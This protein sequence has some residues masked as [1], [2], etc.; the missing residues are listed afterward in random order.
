MK[1][2]PNNCLLPALALV[3]CVVTLRAQESL[4]QTIEFNRDIRPILSDTCYKCHG[5]D[6]AR[7]KADLRLDVEASAKAKIDDHFTIVPGQ[8]G[9]S[10]LIRRITTSDED[11]HMP[12]ADSGVTL[13]SRQ[14]SLLRRWIEQGAKWQAHWSLI[15]PKRPVVPKVQD[16]KARIYNPIDN[17]V[18]A[19][20]ER[21]GI[22]PAP[23]AEPATLIRR[24]SLDLTG[25]PPTPE[26]VTQFLADCQAEKESHPAGT[27]HSAPGTEHSVPGTA[28]SAPATA[29]SALSTSATASP[30][31]YER[32]VDHLLASHSYGERMASRWL[33]AA[34]YADT[35]GYQSD[36][37]RSMWRW[38]DWVIDAF[39]R[40]LPFDRFSV[41]QLAG[42]LLPG[43]TREQHIA[44]GFNRNHRGNAEGGIIPEE[45]AAEYVVDRVDTTATVWLGLTM[46][47]ARCH[48]HKYDPVTQREFYQVF[49]FFNTVPEKGKAIKIGNSPPVISAPTKAQ[50]QALAKLE[51]QLA[52]A[53]ARLRA[54]EPE[55]A[56]AQSAWEKTLAAAPPA[57][58]TVT[59]GLQARYE[60]DGKLANTF[61]KSP[62][63]KFEEGAATFAP[64]RDGMAAA[65]DGTRFINCGDVGDFGFF[66][67]FTLAAWIKPH[68]SEGGAIVSRMVEAAADSAFASDSEGYRVH[69][70]DG[71]VQLHLTKRWLDDALRVET[72]AALPPDR[73]QHVAVVYDGS[74]LASGVKIFVNGQPQKLR[75]LFDQLN[76]TFQTKQPLRIGAGG[77][78]ANRFHGLVSD[79]RVYG[80]MLSAEEIGIVGTTAD[81]TKLAAIP[82]PQRTTSQAAKLRSCFLA[83]HASASQ[84]A[85]QTQV[86]AL[87]EKHAQLVESLPTV[88]VMEEM[89]QPRDTF[90]L[91][92][93]EYDKRGEQVTPNV[94]AS[95]PPLPAD[96]AHNRLGFAQWLVSPANPLTARVAV[97]HQWQMLFG[98]GLV[99]TAEDFGAQGEPPS[100]PE[101]LDWLATEFMRTGWDVKHSLK[102]MVMSAA[103][104]QSSRLTPD[105]LARDPENRLIA[106]GPRVRLPA[107]MIRDQA[108]AVSGLLVDEIGGPSVKPYQPKGL[109]KEL[110]GTD[111]EPDHGDKLWRRSLYTFW[112]RTSPQPTMTTFDAAGRE[113][114]SVRPSRTSTPLQALALMND[115]TFVEA[116]RCLAQRVMHEGGTT[117]EERLRLA[118][119]LVLA[120]APRPP[121][122]AVLTTDLTDHLTRF[123]ASPQSAQSLIS[124]GESAHD[125][126][127]DAVELAAYTAVAGLILNLDEAITKQ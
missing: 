55:I 83:E 41:E 85:A 76:Q 112:K 6:K 47:C 82:S 119:R 92:R 96:A 89:A 115:V 59:Q 60:L 87:R 118:F 120:R 24:V 39:N 23:E 3:A 88:M 72:E 71:R 116:S 106:R 64:G 52:T 90:V 113:M 12:P 86:A 9:Q 51:T 2:R 5:P 31:A 42:D 75:V 19:R 127:L 13:T 63:A 40:N 7:R 94:P 48:D 97:N 95:L 104:R 8:P 121:E 34:R 46:G 70:K 99:K 124:A 111:Y 84:R 69:L 100:H 122:L 15:A 123:R 32:L 103:Y 18:L 73:W 30:T 107:E 33:D 102:T 78:P 91:K 20:L 108:L 67:K 125:A 36:G 45:Y 38:R 79:V 62:A 80:R 54:A 58:W 68:G 17:F 16:S 126:K 66:D 65:L 114:C 57:P 25:L 26:E 29:H 27:E 98:T 21:E 1:F 101:L 43:A 81:T 53:E 77:G 22:Q 117:P 49:A 4:P 37:E 105:L 74:R 14:A 109:Q 61:G 110:S 50:D 10:E 44:T 11:D 28:H 56:A 93:G 35:N